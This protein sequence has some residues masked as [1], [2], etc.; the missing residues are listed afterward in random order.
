MPI[1]INAE[2]LRAAPRY[3]VQVPII[4]SFG[5]ADITV[6]DFSAVGV[7][8]R[9]Y[10]PLKLG[11]ESR[12]NVAVGAAQ[13]KLSIRGKVV[14]S[15][16]SKSPDGQGKHPYVSGLRILETDPAIYEFIE[17]LVAHR[18]AV[19][20]RES[21]DKKRKVLRDKAKERAA[22][23]AVKT[24]NPM[25]ASTDEQLM[26]QHARERLLI[27]PDEAKKWYARAKFALSSEDQSKV[28]PLHYREEVLAVW[29]FLERSI[30]IEKIL[31]VF[32]E[33]R[34]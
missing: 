14:W 16:L 3:V 8:V 6:I 1:E 12:L 10:E 11:S 19:P 13:E 31:L 24:I 9:H 29:E 5:A 22:R 26:I 20:D 2:E 28:A 33:H 7:Q 21:I 25:N 32:E 4:G 17:R 27:H 34:K 30:D 18:A 23:M 15:H